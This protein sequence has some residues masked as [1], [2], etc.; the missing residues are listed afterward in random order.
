MKFV[1]AINILRILNKFYEF[2]MSVYEQ[3]I[4]MGIILRQPSKETNIFY[5]RGV[6]KS[7]ELENRSC[8]IINY[9]SLY[10][11]VIFL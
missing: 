8:S 5:I 7:H 1:F 11:Y 2:L 9:A 6:V 10:L 3:G 4:D